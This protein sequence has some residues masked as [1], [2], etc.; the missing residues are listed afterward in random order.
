M[1]KHKVHV[2][3]NLLIIMTL[4]LHVEYNGII[5]KV[6]VFHEYVSEEYI[7]EYLT[8]TNCV[9]LRA[10]R[11]LNDNYHSY[12]CRRLLLISLQPSHASRPV[13]VSISSSDSEDLELAVAAVVRVSTASICSPRPSALAGRSLSE[14]EQTPAASSPC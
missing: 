12:T 7:T 3:A 9:K 1:H 8:S 2:A 11:K 13:S 14:C 4:Y 10:C 5:Y 6:H